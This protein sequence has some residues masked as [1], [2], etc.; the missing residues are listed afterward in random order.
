MITYL[1]N[2]EKFSNAWKTEMFPPGTPVSDGVSIMPCW[3]AGKY[4]KDCNSINEAGVC[5]DINLE[6]L[7]RLD[8][9]VPPGSGPKGKNGSKGNTIQKLADADFNLLLMEINKFMNRGIDKVLHIEFLLDNE[10]ELVLMENVMKH[11]TNTSH[12]EIQYPNMDTKPK[13]QY[14]DLENSWKSITIRMGHK[15]II[16]TGENMYA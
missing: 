5:N 8:F 14:K 3:K 4:Y 9:K 10:R 13:L 11:S 6:N 12:L 16:D 2:T 7:V 15:Q 1:K